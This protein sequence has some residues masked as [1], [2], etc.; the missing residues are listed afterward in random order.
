MTC[1][2]HCFP[3]IFQIQLSV[4]ASCGLSSIAK[5]GRARARLLGIPS[6]NK[7]APSFDSGPSEFRS[8][9][10]SI[11]VCAVIGEV[12]TVSAKSETTNSRI[13]RLL[14]IVYLKFSHHIFWRWVT[15]HT[16]SNMPQIV[17]TKQS[18]TDNNLWTICTELEIPGLSSRDHP[19][20]P[21]G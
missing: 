21:S 3:R 16:L 19:L 15:V 20:R 4:S 9:D 8:S 18:I 10:Q 2:W 11:P 12:V 5:R 17:T 14:P 7:R 13:S 6:M 1:L